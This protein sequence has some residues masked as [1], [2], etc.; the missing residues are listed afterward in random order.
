MRR[1]KNKK[2][3]N[4]YMKLGLASGSGRGWWEKNV[5]NKGTQ[6]CNKRQEEEEEDSD[7]AYYASRMRLTS[8]RSRGAEEPKENIVKMAGGKE[9]WGRG[10]DGWT[11]FYGTEIGI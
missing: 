9:C 1:N 10:V 11:L 7:K 3:K 4:E 6:P 2:D 5:P 8:S